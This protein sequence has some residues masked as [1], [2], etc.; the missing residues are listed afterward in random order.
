MHMCMNN[1]LPQTR[2]CAVNIT[3]DYDY[4]FSCYH[5]NFFGGATTV[6]YCII[7]Y[8]LFQCYIRTYSLWTLLITLMHNRTH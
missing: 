1:E 8:L 4:I 5:L 2:S 6:Y 3:A 7:N